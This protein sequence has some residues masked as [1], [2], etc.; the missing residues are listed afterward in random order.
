MQDLIW[1]ATN[2][3]LAWQLGKWSI[4]VTCRGREKNNQIF[5]FKIQLDFNQWSKLFNVSRL[6]ISINDNMSW[7]ERHWGRQYPPPRICVSYCCFCCSIIKKDT[8]NTLVVNQIKTLIR[9]THHP[10]AHTLEVPCRRESRSHVAPQADHESS[11]ER[12]DINEQKSL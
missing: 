8:G 11:E 2:Y 7:H 9:L 10:E 12:A 1:F 6:L 5:L 3:L 4:C